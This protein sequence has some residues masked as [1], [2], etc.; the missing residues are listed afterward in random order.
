[1]TRIRYYQGFNDLPP[2]IRQRILTRLG[3]SGSAVRYHAKVLNPPCTVAMDGHQ[4]VGWSVVFEPDRK[5]EIPRRELHVFVAPD[6]RRKGI[7]T[8][9][10][11]HLLWCSN[12]TGAVAALPQND[13]AMQF[14][15]TRFP[16][17]RRV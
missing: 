3:V 14:F 2:A 5:Y 10:I 9:L 12:I 4:P 1:M 16:A 13:V 6:Y 7:A 11:S 8:R 17:I 15:Q